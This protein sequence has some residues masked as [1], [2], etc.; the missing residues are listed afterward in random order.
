MCRMEEKLGSRLCFS[1]KKPEPYLI[2]GGFKA[3]RRSVG[4]FTMWPL[5]F[6]LEQAVRI[7]YGRSGVH[8]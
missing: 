6:Q 4:S 5:D 2:C 7:H 1:R 3:R 8:T